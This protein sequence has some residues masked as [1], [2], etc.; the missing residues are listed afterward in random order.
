MS[1]SRTHWSE[2]HRSKVFAELDMLDLER[3]TRVW[4]VRSRNAEEA[5]AATAIAVAPSH[6]GGVKAEEPV[7]VGPLPS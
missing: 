6:E 4:V 5:V 7:R 1:W 2:C 3:T